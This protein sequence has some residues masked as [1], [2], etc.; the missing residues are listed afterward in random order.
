MVDV[1][2]RTVNQ[3]INDSY[4]LIGMYTENRTPPSFRIIEAIDALNAIID[5]FES[6]TILIPYAKTMSFTATSGK[7]DY[8]I[9]KE[10]GADVDYDKPTKIFYVQIL[11]GNVRYPVKAIN[12][13]IFFDSRSVETAR[14][15]PIYWYMQ[16]T[17][18]G[19]H[20][21]FYPAPA[22]NYTVIVKGK[23]GEDNL[24]NGDI[25]SDKI[26]PSYFLFLQH[27]V[28]RHL[29]MYYKTGI[30]DDK[31]E[32]NYQKLLG[33]FSA[34]NDKDLSMK[35]SDELSGKRISPY[36]IFTW[37]PS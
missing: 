10:V 31:N 26:T 29:A 3:L 14:G 30:W 4:K 36:P 25:L 28:A 1:S 7:R 34:R 27:A 24:Y 9:S 32:D 16:Q 2:T 19:A 17:N 8:Y 18:L 33:N 5:A 21:I 22:Y 15:I 13:N 6:D 12:D 23:F 37:T 11:Y 35:L 20:L